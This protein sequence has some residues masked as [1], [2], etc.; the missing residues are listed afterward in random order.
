MRPP[1]G[2]LSTHA[3]ETHAHILK[4]PPS[5]INTPAHLVD[6]AK[7][8]DPWRREFGGR[9]G[10]RGSDREGVFGR[11]WRE[12]GGEAASAI[13]AGRKYCEKVGV[14]PAESVDVPG[15]AVVAAVFAAPRVTVNPRPVKVAPPEERKGRVESKN[16]GEMGRGLCATECGTLS[17]LDGV[18]NLGLRT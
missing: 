7:V 17:Q 1:P 13:V 2:P 16:R 11:S 9:D 14:V 6:G 18:R 4:I 15:E 8:P 5:R 3:H 10:E 12:D